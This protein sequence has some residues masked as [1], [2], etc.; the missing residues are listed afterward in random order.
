MRTFVIVWSGQLVSAIGS[1]MTHFAITLWAWQLTGQA[2]ALT[3]I[4]F[5]SQVASLVVTPFAG[6]IVDR[7]DRKKLMMLSDAVAALSTVA[8]L[9]LYLTGH[10]QVWHF[11]VTSA[12]N[13]VFS[14][15]QEIAYSASIPM[16]V[17]K[18]DYTRASSMGSVL[19]Y[20]SNIFAPALAGIL[21][22]SIGLLG[23]LLIDLLTFCIAILTVFRVHIP[24]PV[25]SRPSLQS[26]TT[27][28]QEMLVGFR[29]VFAQPGLF[30]LLVAALLF[31]FAHDIGASLYSAMVLARSN[32]NASVLASLSAIA[33]VSG[34]IGAIIMSTLGGPKRKIH[35]FLLGMV[36]AGIS[37]AIFGLGQSPL[38]WF[39]SQFCS[40][41]NFPLL[42]SSND[43]IWLAKVSPERQGRVVATRSLLLL[44]VSTIAALMAGP[45]ADRI[46]EPAMMPEGWLAGIFGSIFGTGSGAG[47]ALLYV[48][49]SIGLVLV[50]TIGYWIPT[51]RDMET[52]VCDH[53]V[54]PYS[55]K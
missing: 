29:Y 20:S 11:Y 24:Q 41:L 1:Y 48:I 42:G 44:V 35:G 53:D 55:S 5:S 33:G 19:H 27:L 8:I 23:I 25:A 17:S 52:T 40:S 3:L 7:Y 47:M 30:A 13:G 37:K 6:V 31:W 38:L 15:L 9:S 2:T 12:I 16:M 43:A 45:L 28:L 26:Q 21:Y 51:L 4:I 54:E 22:Y 39:P 14:D 34:V 50:G 46:F 49:S 10:L 32:N 36:G 18:Q